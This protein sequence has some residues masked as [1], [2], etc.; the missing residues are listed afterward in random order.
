MIYLFQT[1]IGASNSQQH[2]SLSF[3]VKFCCC[4]F[5]Y[6]IFGASIISWSIG[7]TVDVVLAEINCNLAHFSLVSRFYTPWKRQK[8]KGF[9]TFSGGI[10]MWHW[11]KMGQC[12]LNWYPHG[13]LRCLGKAKFFFL[14]TSFSDL[15]LSAMFQIC[16]TSTTHFC[17]RN[18]QQVNPSFCYS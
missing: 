16:Q 18:S 4:I 11:T 9:L 10:E 5:L 7:C 13:M 3:K 1:L 14:E 15:R 12:F 17:W 2:F 8:T 6:F